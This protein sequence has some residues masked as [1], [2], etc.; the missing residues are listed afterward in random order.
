M[1]TLEWVLIKYD[2]CAYKEEATRT[3]T[4]RGNAT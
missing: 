3:E 2:W 4:R 1:R